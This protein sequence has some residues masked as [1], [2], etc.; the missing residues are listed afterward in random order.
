MKRLLALPVCL[1]AS[2]VLGCG[3]A[4]ESAPPAEAPPPAAGASALPDLPQFDA[5]VDELLGKMTLAEKVGQMTQADMSYIAD[6][7]SLRRL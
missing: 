4:P 7:G 1:A 3:P 5:R 6:D 2:V